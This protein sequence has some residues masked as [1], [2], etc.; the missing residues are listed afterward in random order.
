M[1]LWFMSYIRKRNWYIHVSVRFYFAKRL[2]QVESGRVSG[3]AGVRHAFYWLFKYQHLS[4]TIIKILKRGY[5]FIHL[6]IGTKQ[7]TAVK[8]YQDRQPKRENLSSFICW[9]DIVN[10]LIRLVTPRFSSYQ[11]PKFHSVIWHEN[12][13][14]NISNIYPLHFMTSDGDFVQTHYICSVYCSFRYYE[15]T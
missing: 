2:Q 10:N 7:F 6:H 4:S 3:S 1:P 15:E 9:F 5:I 14:L 11:D 12:V 13:I 8:N